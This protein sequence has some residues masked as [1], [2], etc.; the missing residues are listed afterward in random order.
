MLGDANISSVLDKNETGPYYC[1]SETSTLN[2]LIGA[3][4]NFA[5]GIIEPH[6]VTTSS[7]AKLLA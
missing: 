4:G 7:I 2:F 6:L 3:E 5:T 1:P